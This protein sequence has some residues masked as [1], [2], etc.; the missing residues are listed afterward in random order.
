MNV[1][2]MR[3][4]AEN[5][6]DTPINQVGITPQEHEA[7]YTVMQQRY[8]N[9]IKYNPDDIP[10][11]EEYCIILGMLGGFQPSKRQPLPGLKILTRAFDKYHLIL[12][13]FFITNMSKN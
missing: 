1:M 8:P 6:P 2:K 11:I 7:L 9:K 5:H 10:T 3:Y 12:D 4:L 13:I